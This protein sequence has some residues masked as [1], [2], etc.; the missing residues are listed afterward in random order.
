MKALDEFRVRDGF[1]I[2][3]HD[4]A[5][6]RGRTEADITEPL[7]RN[8]DRIAELQN[9]LYAEKKQ[10][11][12]VVLQS[13]DTGGKD[14]IIRDVLRAV[15]P[16]ACRVTAFKK[17][18]DFE[19]GH[20]HFWRFHAVVPCRGEIGVFNRSYYDEIIAET[21]HGELSDER[22]RKLLDM[23][24]QFER[25]LAEHGTVIIKLYL[26]MSR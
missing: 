16:Q 3:D 7:R 8:I 21:A 15:N 19:R 24:N 5:D 12:L 26:H 4:P 9:A 11:L 14:P 2:T 18:T 25:T 22:R 13:M 10:S 23:S 6:A 20:D 17:P 1:R